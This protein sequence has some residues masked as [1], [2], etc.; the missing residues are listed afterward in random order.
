MKA[1]VTVARYMAE[2]GETEPGVREYI[3]R[4]IEDYRALESKTNTSETSWLGFKLGCSEA[5]ARSAIR[6]AEQ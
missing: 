6:W 1:P 5:K 3:L 4:Q 2:F